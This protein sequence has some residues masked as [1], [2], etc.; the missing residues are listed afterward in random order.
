[1]RRYCDPSLHNK[2]GERYDG[3]VE[4]VRS[5]PDAGYERCSVCGMSW[6]Q[7]YARPADIEPDTWF[8]RSG[9]SV[10]R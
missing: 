10:S 9:A 8:I 4:L 6:I 5:N 7:V 1:M 2:R 3:R